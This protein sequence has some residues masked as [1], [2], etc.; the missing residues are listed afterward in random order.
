LENNCTSLE[1]SKKLR[2]AGFPQETAFHYSLGDLY[3]IHEDDLSG[4]TDRIAAPTSTEI[5]LAGNKDS[6]LNHAMPEDAA[7][8]WLEINTKGTNK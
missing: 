7:R 6:R 4:E 2:D 5:Y 1:T 3:Y 8:A